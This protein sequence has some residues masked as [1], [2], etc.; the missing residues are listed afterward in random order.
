M[1]LTRLQTNIHRWRKQQQFELK[2]RTIENKAS[3]TLYWYIRIN[4]RKIV[5][6]Y[7][8]TKE[9]AEKR[10]IRGYGRR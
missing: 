9:C 5:G 10:L 3:K 1:D 4:Q 7:P 2:R 8:E 6:E